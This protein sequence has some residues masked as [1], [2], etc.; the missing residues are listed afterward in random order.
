MLPDVSAGDVCCGGSAAR[1]EPDVAKHKY[2]AIAGQRRH[3][4][5]DLC[6][7]EVQGIDGA[8]WVVY[9]RDC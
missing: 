9:E 3:Q 6:G 8:C 2:A 7:G 4:T 1:E 5:D